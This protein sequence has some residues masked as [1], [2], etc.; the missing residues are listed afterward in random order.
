MKRF[1][2]AAE[3]KETLGLMLGIAVLVVIMGTNARG[4]LTWFNIHNILRDFSILLVVSSG[5]TV[6]IVLGKI[7]IS[8][9]TTMSLSAVIISLMLSR[10]IAIPF[11]LLG[12]LASGA[13]VGALNGYLIGVQKVN[14]F[15]ATFATSSIV[16]GIA[17]VISGGTI[18]HANSRHIVWIG[19]G[20]ILNLFVIIWIGMLI[21]IGM[22]LLLKKTR[23][24]YKIYS[25]GGSEVIAELSGLKTERVYMQSFILIGV[26]SAMAGLLLAG[27]T[28][29][30]N[31][32]MADGFEFNAIAIVLIGGTPFVGGRGGVIGTFA[33][34]LFIAVL[35]NGI[36]MMGFGVSWQFA[37]IGI[38]IL[39]VVSVS[40]ILNERRQREETR[41][42]WQ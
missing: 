25:T 13:A 35:R 31:A 41:R 12:G 5:M 33:G 10:G 28:N 22:H 15:I 38:A 40:T 23:F 6:A 24:G 2:L 21:F 16:R 14:H 20:R 37:I 1:R 3:Y 27:M 9:G 4:F 29:S 18:I 30:G 11:A 32:I 7:D 36:S 19:T 8:A 17:L 34:A 26:L 42:V 39:L